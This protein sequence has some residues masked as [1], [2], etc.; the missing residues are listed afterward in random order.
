MFRSP[1]WTYCSLVLCTRC[2]MICLALWSRILVAAVAQWLKRQ[3]CMQQTGVQ[4][5]LV[6][7]CVNVGSREGIQPKLLP[8]TRK[9]P[10]RRE[11]TLNSDVRCL[12]LNSHSDIWKTGKCFG[13][14]RQPGKLGMSSQIHFSFLPLMSMSLSMSVVYLYSTESLQHINCVKTLRMIVERAL[15][16]C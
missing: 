10:W 12:E 13:I 3:T 4:L 11:S 2:D 7:T 14:G 8:C 1:V 5:P 9:S 15:D 6:L 16:V